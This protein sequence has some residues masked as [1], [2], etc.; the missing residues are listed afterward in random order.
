MVAFNLG[1]LYST[2]SDFARAY[3]FECIIDGFDS[4]LVKTTGLP[5]KTITQITSDWQGNTYKI[6][7]T[8][9][10]SDLN[11][12][13]NMDKEDKVRKD[14]MKWMKDIHNPENN[15]HGSPDAYFKDIILKHLSP[16]NT[17]IIKY[18]FV[19]AWPT[20]IS[21]VSL[22][23]STKEIATFDVSFAYQFHKLE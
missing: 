22:D 21:E 9:E 23:H 14:F 2:H 5:E 12:T 4:L 3:L 15:I 6:G 20:S 13:F 19:D 10:F 17:E 7:G 1:G 16:Q 8:S 18:K 11:I